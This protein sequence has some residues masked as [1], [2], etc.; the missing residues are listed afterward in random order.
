MAVVVASLPFAVCCLDTSPVAAAAVWIKWAKVQLS[1]VPCLLR[2]CAEPVTVQPVPDTSFKLPHALSS[3]VNQEARV[4]VLLCVV[5]TPALV[6]VAA[7]AAAV[8]TWLTDKAQEYPLEGGLNTCITTVLVEAAVM[9][10]EGSALQVP[11]NL[12]QK[13]RGDT[14]AVPVRTG[15]SFQVCPPV[16]LTVKVILDALLNPIM[17][18]R[19]PSSM[20]AGGV[21]ATVAAPKEPLSAGLEELPK[22]VIT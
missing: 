11:L 3:A 18:T 21:T 14:F 4:R 15:N 19:S 22:Y 5:V 13:I 8:D 9:A 12:H 7:A 6:M 2:Y 17:S 20:A 16:A 10:T 1:S